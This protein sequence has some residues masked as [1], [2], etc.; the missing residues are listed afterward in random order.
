ME[1][2]QFLGSKI[3]VVRLDPGEDALLSLK[4]LVR[5]KGIEQAVVVSGYGTF[6]R[7]RLHWVAHNRFPTDNLFEEFEDGIELMSM[8]GMVVD[9][10]PHI[11]FTA[12]TPRGAFGGHLE[13]GCIVYVLCEITLVELEGPK[14]KR[15]KAP[16][17]RDEK[18]NP[19]DVPRLV[20][21]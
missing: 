19:V 10:E 7:A 1:A 14:M 12:A 5:R 9:G 18:G 3:W 11:H 2:E 20:F 4:D 8:D 15:L 13:E 17:A 16:V 6:A 21:G